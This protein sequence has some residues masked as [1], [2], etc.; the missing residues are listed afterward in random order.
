MSGELRRQLKVPGEVALTSGHPI[1]S[2]LN[3]ILDEKRLII[4]PRNPR[5]NRLQANV[6]FGFSEAECDGPGQRLVSR[7]A[8]AADTALLYVGIGP[9]T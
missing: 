2:G 4:K 5:N 1:M 3:L 7:T 8:N 9:L 6:R